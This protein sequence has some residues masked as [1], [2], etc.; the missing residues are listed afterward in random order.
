MS[1]L[2]GSATDPVAALSSCC[3]AIV[4]S[5]TRARIYMV[6]SNMS[7]LY[8]S[9]IRP[10]IVMA[11]LQSTCTFSLSVSSHELFPH[12]ITCCCAH[13]IRNPSVA[14]LPGGTLMS[15]YTRVLSSSGNGVLCGDDCGVLAGVVT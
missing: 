7:T 12:G 10:D 8:V 4:L 2:A 11:K 14:E 3:A 9:T 1:T 6:C 5:L 13:M 15:T